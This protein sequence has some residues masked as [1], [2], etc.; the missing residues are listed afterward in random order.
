LA[1]TRKVVAVFPPQQIR[2]F[3]IIAHADHGK[4]I[5]DRLIQS[6]GGPQTAMRPADRRARHHRQRRAGSTTRRTARHQ[7]NPIDTPAWIFP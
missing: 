1:I 4:S 5:A 2:N 3:S 6:C 7:L